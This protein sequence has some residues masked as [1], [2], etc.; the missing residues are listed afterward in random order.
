VVKQGPVTTVSNLH[1]R[2]IDGMEVDIIFA[3]ELIEFNVFRIK[4][5]FFPFWRVVGGDTRIT[6]RRVE[7]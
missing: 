6:D 1:G 7:L 4:P 5:P 2:P 3:H